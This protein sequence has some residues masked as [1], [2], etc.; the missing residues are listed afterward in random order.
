MQHRALNELLCAAMIN[1]NFRETLLA[2]PFLAVNEGYQDHHFAL[3]QDEYDL[4]THIRADSLESFAE[5]V[6]DWMQKQ[7]VL[8]QP[9]SSKIPS[10]HHSQWVDGFV[11]GKEEHWLVPDSFLI[12]ER[13]L[14]PV[15]S[16]ET[17]NAPSN[18]FF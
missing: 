2:D 5:L 9:D 4:V 7:E 18:S 8:C 1:Q 17:V 3:S 11:P 15:E 14:L 13:R 10:R 6:V 16:G 12:P